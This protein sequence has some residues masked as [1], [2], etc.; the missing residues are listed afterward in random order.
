[1]IW[2]GRVSRNLCDRRIL[3]LPR[4]G[5]PDSESDKKKITQ[6]LT[7]LDNA[8]GRGAHHCNLG[9]IA[10]ETRRETD[11]VLCRL[12]WSTDLLHRRPTSAQLAVELGSTETGS[13]GDCYGCDSWCLLRA[14]N[15]E[16]RMSTCSAWTNSGRSALPVPVSRWSAGQRS[17]NAPRFMFDLRRQE[18]GLVPPEL[19]P[20][21]AGP[22][23][24]PRKL[25]TPPVPRQPI[26]RPPRHRV[27]NTRGGQEKMATLTSEYS[28]REG[29]E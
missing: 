22:L 25:K 10:A 28:C 19:R 24:W 13:K 26:R 4:D 7:M 2:L 12:L 11:L 1:M 18:G 16:F 27:T 6:C 20:P 14:H 29:L 3:R 8:S 5:E 21:A 23:L 17:G 9:K 15:F